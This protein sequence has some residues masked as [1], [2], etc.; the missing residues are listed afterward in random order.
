MNRIYEIKNSHYPAD[1]L[2]HLL[3]GCPKDVSKGLMGSPVR[4]MSKLILPNRSFHE[5][6]SDLSILLLL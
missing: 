1:S 4:K 3:C 2:K 6:L 5:H